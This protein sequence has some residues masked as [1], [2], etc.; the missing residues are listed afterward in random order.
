MLI[1]KAQLFKGGFQMNIKGLLPIGSVVL[2]KNAKKRLMVIGVLQ[3]DNETGKEYEYLGVPYPEGNLGTE[4]QFLFD[5]S[6]I[7][8]TFYIGYS[9]KERITFLETLDE[10]YKKDDKGEF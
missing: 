5:G 10:Y 2:L 9:D 6:D 1:G 8:E 7:E 3:V 4:N